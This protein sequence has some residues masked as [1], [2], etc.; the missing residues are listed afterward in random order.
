V[1]LSVRESDNIYT[2]GSTGDRGSRLAP[3]RAKFRCSVNT[4]YDVSG[5]IVPNKHTT[6]L[7]VKSGVVVQ[8][9]AG[10]LVSQGSVARRS[11]RVPE[12][13]LVLYETGL[14]QAP[15]QAGV[16]AALRYIYL[17]FEIL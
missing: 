2:P 12:V 4:A 7:C 5:R 17:G 3:A 8:E 14:T 15:T 6:H 16:A 11:P 10:R 1:S 13:S 9:V